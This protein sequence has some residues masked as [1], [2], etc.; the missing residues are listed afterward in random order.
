M[1][2]SASLSM[3]VG[4]SVLMN[5]K[6]NNP[7]KK[8]LWQKTDKQS[9]ISVLNR[10]LKKNGQKENCSVDQN[11]QTLTEALHAAAAAAVPSMISKLKGPN[12]RASPYNWKMI[13]N[14]FGLKCSQLKLLIL[15]QVGINLL[16]EI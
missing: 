6:P 11:L 3:P 1:S 10:E 4:T 7:V 13:Q 8:L 14:Q 9:Y 16:V 5:N 15:W 12:W 2:V